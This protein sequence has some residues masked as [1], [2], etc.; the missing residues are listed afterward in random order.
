MKEKE[1]QTRELA[2]QRDEELESE[3]MKEQEARRP[4]SRA[5]STSSR[6]SRRRGSSVKPAER[7]PISKEETAAEA[8]VKKRLAQAKEAKKPLVPRATGQTT[9]NISFISSTTTLLARMQAHMTASAGPFSMLQTIM[10]LVVIAWMTNNKKMRDRIRRIL[11]ICWIKMTRTIGMG[12][13]VT[14]V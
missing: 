8:L 3:R 6:T 10:M 14:Y 4:K 11:V 7:V 1:L 12:M 2:K 9:D 13:K 5:P